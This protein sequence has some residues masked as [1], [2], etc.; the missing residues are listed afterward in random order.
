MMRRAPFMPSA[1]RLTLFTAHPPATLPSSI[2][3]RR[4]RGIRV[5]YLDIRHTSGQVIRVTIADKPEFEQLRTLM[6]TFAADRL[7]ADP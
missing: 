7:I 1:L 6:Q 3:V 4:P 5:G 2:E